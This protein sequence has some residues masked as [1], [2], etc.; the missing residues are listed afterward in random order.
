MTE[1][2]S[3]P[4]TEVAHWMWRRPNHVCQLTNHVR[5]KCSN[6]VMVNFWRM[7]ERVDGGVYL[8]G[9]T[10]LAGSRIVRGGV[11]DWYRSGRL[12]RSGIPPGLVPPVA[13][14]S[15]YRRLSALR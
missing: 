12:R 6:D 1:Q 13:D 5:R 2:T 10:G 7:F 8:G 9:S 14:S 4:G 3:A 11:A 15:N